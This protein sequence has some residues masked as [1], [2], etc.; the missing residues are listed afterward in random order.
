PE[1]RDSQRFASIITV[2][3]LL[4]TLLLLGFSIYLAVQLG[5]ITLPFFNGAGT[6]TPVV[7]LIQV[8]DLIGKSWADAQKIATNKDFQLKSKDG[9]SDGTVI[10]QSPRSGTQAIRGSFIEVQM[11]V[12]KAAIPAILPNTTLAA[13]EAQLI[14]TGFNNFIAKSDGLDQN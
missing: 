4:A 12:Q 13:Y 10:D 11:Q 14:K 8:P 2:L 7:T 1:R 3:I 5:F 6:P 9:N